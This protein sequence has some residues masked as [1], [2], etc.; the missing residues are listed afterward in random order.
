M[1][2]L[3]RHKWKLLALGGA[4]AATTALVL[5]T[6]KKKD[7]QD[8]WKMRP[9]ASKKS[10]SAAPKPV[11]YKVAKK[12]APKG[13]AATGSKDKKAASANV[14]RET[15]SGW[16]ATLQKRDA[17]ELPKLVEWTDRLL[18]EKPRDEKTIAQCLNLIQY[19]VEG[20]KMSSEVSAIALKAKDIDPERALEILVNLFKDR[21][22][23]GHV[24]DASVIGHAI[25]TIDEGIKGKASRACYQRA[26]RLLFFLAMED[27][28]REKIKKAEGLEKVLQLM[29]KFPDD[30]GVLLEGCAFTK[31]LVEKPG[32]FPEA[33]VFKAAL[34]CL[35]E[36]H[37][38]NGELQWRALAVINTLPGNPPDEMKVAECA[39]AAAKKHPGFDGVV[40]WVAKVLHKL[41]KVKGGT[42]KAWLKSPANRSWLEEF[43][44]SPGN[45]RKQN[46][47]A[48]H[49]VAELWRLCK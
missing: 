18:K 4:C 15:L 47:E 48:D 17:D 13:D 40:E 32:S 16:V 12:A 35:A 37:R 19:W 31:V 20:N 42:V 49:W 8:K 26:C 44:E 22:H 36:K 14:T 7:S 21:R 1:E 28:N 30:H 2:A 11:G 27:S 29:E 43:R 38:E 41:C 39:V 23:R 24:A 45:I 3:Q 25:S 34:G 9:D 46:K 33:Q 6:R 5:L 10:G